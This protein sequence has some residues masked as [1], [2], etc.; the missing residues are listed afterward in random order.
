M[1]PIHRCQRRG[2]TLTELLVVLAIIG[3]L[4][5]ILLPALNG[6]RCGNGSRTSCLNNLHQIGIALHT[7]ADMHGRKFGK[8]LNNCKLPA[9]TIANSDLSPEQRLSWIVEL[10]PYIEEDALYRQIDRGA[11]WDAPSNLPLSHSR[12]PLLQ[13]NGLRDAIPSPNGWETTYIGIAGVGAN[14]ANLPS[15]SPKIGVFGYDR[16]TSLADIKDG[17]SHTLMVLESAR[18]TGSWAQG[19]LTTVRGID[20]AEKPYL[21]ARR[22]FGGTHFTENGLLRSPHSLGCNGLWADGSGRIL[23]DT[24][25]PEVLEALA[26][27]AG[28]EMIPQDY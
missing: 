20:P 12:L 23:S 21:G 26:T 18:D 3:V 1:Y 5:L 14:A 24:I 11:G 4:L 10:L 15:D 13:C 28:G 17:T 16:Q 9:G 19:G 27:I 8:G 7:Y 22:P 6:I 2:L 25:A